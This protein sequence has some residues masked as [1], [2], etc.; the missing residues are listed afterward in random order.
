MKMLEYLE[1]GG[2]L[3]ILYGGWIPAR[4]EELGRLGSSSLAIAIIHVDSMDPVVTYNRKV[5]V[6]TGG[7]VDTFLPMR[8][9]KL[10]SQ[11]EL[12]E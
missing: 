5:V 2:T 9:A 4:T 11:A 6:E 7:W 3:W 8:M 10:N 1:G 12:L